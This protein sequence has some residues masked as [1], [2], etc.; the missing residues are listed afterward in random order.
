MSTAFSYAQAARGQVP[1]P[2]APQSV[3]SQAG[4]VA[5]SQNNDA[6][7]STTSDPPSVAP[8]SSPNEQ[9]AHDATTQ[10]PGQLSSATKPESVATEQQGKEDSAI[11]TTAESSAPS[12]QDK[13]PLSDAASQTER[14]SKATSATRASDVSD[15]RKARKGKK[16][17]SAEKDSEQ[18][19]AASKEKEVEEQKPQVPLADAP[20]PSVNI[21]AQRAKEAKAKVVPQAAPARAAASQPATAESKIET[22]AGQ[23]RPASNVAKSQKKD[24]VRD[25]GDQVSRKTLPK[26]GRV[27]EKAGSEALPAVSDVTS[28]PTPETAATEIKAP[29]STGKQAENEESAEDKQDSGPKGKQQWKKIPI[30]PT[31]KWDTPVPTRTPRGGRTGSSGRG[32]R[33]AGTRG[34]HA[35]AT[36]SIDRTQATPRT[37]R[38]GE[39]AVNAARGSSNSA[40]ANKR[41]SV[42]ASASRDR[43]ASGSKEVTKATSSQPV[44]AVDDA[45][46]PADANVN[47]VSQQQVASENSTATDARNGASPQQIDASKDAPAQVRDSSHHGAPRPDRRGGRGGRGGANGQGHHGAYPSNGQGFAG[48]GA[49]PGRQSSFPGNMPPMGYGMPGAPSTRGSQ[50]NSASGG[51]NGRNRPQSLQAQPNF[52]MDPSMHQMSAFPPQPYP[53]EQTLMN[54]LVKQ[55]SYYFSVNN[56]IKDSW[57][58]KSMDSQGYV[59]L[60]VILSFSRMR[61]IA[62]Q[63]EL[64]KAAC[65]ECPDIEL[66]TGCEDGRDRVRRVDDWQKYIYPKGSR[67][68]AVNF[69]DGPHNVW[70]W[71]QGYQQWMPPY[72][73]AM[74]PYQ[75]E[76]P[77]YYQPNGAPFPGYMN[78][79]SEQHGMING[80]NGHAAPGEPQLSAVAPE[81]SPK[82]GS[83][84]SDADQNGAVAGKSAPL[85]N[86]DSS[87]LTN[88]TGENA[89]AYTNGVHAD[90]E[91]AGH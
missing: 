82:G 81:F 77:G 67:H 18:D 51:R 60:D 68:D 28:W 84:A 25:S 7:S 22:A 61:E 58:R 27:G 45:S 80:V 49:A 40:Q 44:N 36:G 19:Q 43:K 87:A 83:S 57:L 16:S 5:S 29:D 56:L 33:E 37:D 75:M 39:N 23:S 73:P 21:W 38:F 72:Q 13:K 78:D 2:P 74:P 17:K 70:R 46:T 85:A 14:R 9:S 6:A 20:L 76:V 52:S 3:V 34:S 69:D 71:G 53:Y 41:A 65:I 12:T 88:G 35:G 90:V 55:L 59:F 10:A 50:R 48:P 8:S 63:M 66:V 15:N 42:D 79:A 62:T 91:V 26:G 1:N 24:T 32:G 86:G 89:Q 30:V 47:G 64:V 54:M 31:I 11:K 4:S